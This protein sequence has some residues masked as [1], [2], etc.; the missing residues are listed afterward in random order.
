MSRQARCDSTPAV[1]SG[2]VGSSSVDHGGHL[3]VDGAGHDLGQ[4][5]GHAVAE[6]RG[7][8]DPPARSGPQR[9][10]GH[11]PSKAS[12]TTPAEADR[13][14]CN[15]ARPLCRGIIRTTIS[16]NDRL[17]VQVRRAADARG[18]SVSAFITGILDDALKRSEPRPAVPPFRL[19][20]ARGV[21]PRPGVDLDRP[22]AVDAQEDEARSDAAGK[23]VADA[24]HAAVAIEHGCTMVSTDSDFGRF[25]ELRCHHPLRPGFS[26]PKP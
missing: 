14:V 19:I 16:L 5:G 9:Q 17:A 3:A 22:R 25:P 4:A 10:V 26:H 15:D 20:T 12:P 8:D 1:D 18:V 21:R 6:A 23:L 2:E 13:R 24:Q 7:V 11:A